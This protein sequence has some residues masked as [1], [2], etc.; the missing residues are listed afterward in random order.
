M[1]KLKKFIFLFGGLIIV[2]LIAFLIPESKREMKME[3]FLFHYSSSI[4]REKITLL[5]NALEAN[6]DRI[7]NDLKTTPSSNIEVTIYSQRW[8]YIKATKNWELRVILKESQNFI[9]LNKPGANPT[10][11]KLRYTSLLIQLL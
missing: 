6:Y 3:H 8:R 11:T 5:A 7:R 9:L 4:D 10:T 2:F 1:K